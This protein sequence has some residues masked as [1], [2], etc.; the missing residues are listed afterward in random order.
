MFQGPEPTLDNCTEKDIR[1]NHVKLPK[2]KTHCKQ[3]RIFLS[4]HSCCGGVPEPGT[5][6]AGETG[7]VP[8][9]TSSLLSVV[10]CFPRLC[11]GDL[12]GMGVK[13]VFAGTANLPFE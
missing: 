6:D 8:T 3:N 10:L 11:V 9:N 12:T 5:D 7:G 1:M 2:K 4:T 13:D